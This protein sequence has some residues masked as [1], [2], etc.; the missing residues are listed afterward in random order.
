[1]KYRSFLRFVLAGL[2]VYTV[3]CGDKKDDK[4]KQD[5]IALNANLVKKDS[6]TGK[7]KAQL[8][9]IVSK[10][11]K[12][13]YKVTA[14]TFTT[15]KSPATENKEFSQNNE[16]NYFYTKEV[17]DVDNN[18]IVTYKVKFDSII[19]TAKM[20]TIEVK[21]N[22]NAHD[23]VRNNPA[24]FQY[25]S[26]VNENFYIRV[27]SEGEITDVYGMEKI[28][29]NLFKALGDTLK[30]EEKMTI[31][32]S[33]GKESIKEVLQQ[34]YQIF[35]KNEIH[36]DSSWVKSYTTQVLFFDVVNSAK[37]T[38]KGFED[39]NNQKLANIEASLIVDFLTKE[40]KEKGVKFK[41]ENAETSGQGKIVVNLSRGCITNK[42]TT[43]TLKLE[44]SLSAQGQ[45]AKTHQAVTTNLIVTLLNP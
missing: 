37:Y 18:G 40:V 27:S 21:Y 20:D 12:F 42:E 29:E 16:I 31:K 9:Y 36:A 44:L 32:E 38:L 4:T 23:S 24:F 43:T 5:V 8:K 34:E 11:D 2:I 19:I 3:G 33:F 1:M 14:K 25:N 28:Y 26:V 22:S 35:P 41:I 15:E 10:G 7:E 6:L 13:S 17:T 30:E 45:S 39:K